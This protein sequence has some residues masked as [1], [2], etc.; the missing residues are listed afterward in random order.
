MRAGQKPK[1][2]PTQAEKA[3]ASPTELG[4]TTA[5]QPAKEDRPTETPTPTATAQRYKRLA[6]DTD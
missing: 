1:T 4:V 6:S 3:N 2:T 5:A